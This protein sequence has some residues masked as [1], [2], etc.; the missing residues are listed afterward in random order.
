MRAEHLDN[1]PLETLIM[2]TEIRLSIPAMK[3]NG[4]TSSIENALGESGVP[5]VEL[6]LATK[7][8]VIKSDVSVSTLIGTIKSAGFDASEIT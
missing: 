5:D 2:S 8:A 3:C 7:T 4:C 1:K 6:D